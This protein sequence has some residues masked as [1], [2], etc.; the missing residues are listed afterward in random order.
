MKTYISIAVTTS[1]L[2][3]SNISFADS[4]EQGAYFYK[5]GKYRSAHTILNPLLKKG[6]AC[7]EY[8]IGLMYQGGNNVKQNEINRKKG[9]KLINSASTKGYQAAKDFLGSYH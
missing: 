4:C 7:A 1:F 5:K 2:L 8:Y 3:F 6:E 9:I